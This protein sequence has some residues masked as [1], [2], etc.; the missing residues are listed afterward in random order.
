MSLAGRTWRLERTSTWEEQCS[1]V[2][3][4]VGAVCLV[5]GFGDGAVLV[6]AARSWWLLRGLGG[7]WKVTFCGFQLLDQC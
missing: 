2:E 5:G 7:A 6:L 3:G 1:S 4:A